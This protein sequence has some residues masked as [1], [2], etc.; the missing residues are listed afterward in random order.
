MNMLVG[1]HASNGGPDIGG[2]LTMGHFVLSIR[3]SP[4]LVLR[5]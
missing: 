2:V 3:Y 4:K 5:S 1:V